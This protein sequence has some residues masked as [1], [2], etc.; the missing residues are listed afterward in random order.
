MGAN[1][2]N[3]HKLVLDRGVIYVWSP[4]AITLIK[5]LESQ[6][7]EGQHSNEIIDLHCKDYDS[8]YFKQIFLSLY[9]RN[10][11]QEKRFVPID[12][13]PLYSPWSEPSKNP[14]FQEY[15]KFLLNEYFERASTGEFKNVNT[16]KQINT[17]SIDNPIAYFNVVI[18]KTLN[19]DW[20]FDQ[21]IPWN[22]GFIFN[23]SN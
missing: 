11:A 3:Y 16:P 19:T 9:K 15:K 20:Y 10:P 12:D 8:I 18:R 4:E 13:L 23:Y 6:Q 1:K 2:T 14:K 17:L 7:F 21:G 22:I 5:Q